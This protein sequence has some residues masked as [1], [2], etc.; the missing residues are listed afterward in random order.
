MLLKKN[1]LFFFIYNSIK[2][3]RYYMANMEESDNK[4]KILT[5]LSLG[6]LMAGINTSIANVSLPNI[7][8]YFQ[9]NLSVTGLVSTAYFISFIGFALFASKLGDRYGHDKIFII[10]VISFVVTSILCSIAPSIE[11]LIFCRFLQGIAGSIL[12]SGPMVILEKAFSVIHLGKAYGIYSVFA[13]VGLTIGPAIGG[14]LQGMFNWR[15]IFLI[16]VPIGILTFFLS[17]YSLDK[18]ETMDVRWDIKGLIGIFL[19]IALI[20]ATM[21]FIEDKDYIYF[22]VSLILSLISMVATIKIE[23]NAEDPLLNLRLFKNKT[24]ATSSIN[25][26]LAYVAEYLFIYGLPY[27][28][29]K[30][31]HDGS[32]MVGLILS[33]AP[34]LMIFIAPLSGEI[35][36]RKGY[37]LPTIAGCI[38]C[39]ISSILII[40]TNTES[41]GLAIFIIF[42]IYGIGCGLLQSPINKAIMISVPEKYSGTAS[43][44]IQA[45]RNL[46]ISFAVCYGSLIYALSVSAQNMQ[47]NVLFGSAAQQLTSGLHY[48]AIFSI[49]LSVIVI[50]L[51]VVGKNEKKEKNSV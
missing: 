9:S 36:D 41:H 28:L 11:L 46:G 8:I 50:I 29:E 51:T 26:H 14:I 20:I 48:I 33:A 12:L 15:A 6:V 13:A 31:V 23:Q 32:S 49:I 10:G 16:N 39:I 19:S 1:N 3:G 40:G 21:T 43:G 17:V 25:L 22:F 35:T 4:W 42:A 38:I 47:K 18:I 2:V 30:V 45:S 27:F 37:V 24:F 7:Q 44:V 34:I 5:A